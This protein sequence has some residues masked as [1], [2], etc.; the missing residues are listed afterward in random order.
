MKG[1]AMHKPTTHKMNNVMESN[2]VLQGKKSNN[3]KFC[4]KNN[5]KCFKLKFFQVLF[6]HDLLIWV[7]SK[8][9][10]EKQ[11]PLNGHSLKIF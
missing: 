2:K 11:P 6:F 7:C 5:I 3:T 8:V 1:R 10:G 4:T 9:K